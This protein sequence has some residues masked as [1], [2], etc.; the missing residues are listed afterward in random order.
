MAK[1]A[2][3]VTVT[4]HYYIPEVKNILNE[5][6]NPQIVSRNSIYDAFQVK[7]VSR[8]EEYPWPTS[9]QKR[10]ITVALRLCGY[11]KNNKNSQ[12]FVKGGN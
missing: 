10:C 4:K 2:G 12:I 5:R 8:K 9:Y 6:D 11:T 7:T 1:V 3:I